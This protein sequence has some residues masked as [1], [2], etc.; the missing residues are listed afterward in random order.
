LLF[1]D[2]YGLNRIYYHECKEGLYFSSEAK[3]L[4]KVLPELRHFNYDSFGET[5]SFGCVLQNRT[6]FKGIYL[7]PG[8]SLWKC[9]PGQ[10]IQKGSYF[11][12]SIWENQELLGETEYYTKLRETWSR[13]LPRYLRGKERVAISLTGGKDT[14]MIMAWLRSAPNALPCYTFGGLYRDCEDVKLARQIAKI[15][16]QSHQVIR[17]DRTFFKEFPNLAE[18]TVYLTDG[19]M[20]VSGS[21]ELFVNRVARQI[22]PIRLTGNYG[23]EILYSSI[24]FKPVCWDSGILEKE[25]QRLTEH[26]ANTYYSELLDN[27]LSFVAFKQV[28]WHHYSRL[29]LELSQITPRS[30]YLDNELVSLA[31]RAPRELVKCIEIQLRL[32]MDGNQALGKV[33]TD[34]GVLYKP[35]P[36]FNKINRLSK[37]FTFKAEYAYDYGMP[38]LLVRIDHMFKHFHLE[39][40]FL[41]RHKFCHFRIWYRDELS[42]YLKEILLDRRSI[43]RGYLNGRRLENMVMDHIKGIRNYTSD[44]HRIL[45]AELIQRHFID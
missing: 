28:P 8:G 45:T 16:Q 5:F 21:A 23:Q 39:K 30:P 43:T 29:S 12:Q 9:S 36:L 41:G 25:F 4:L 38:R 44:I 34:R 6:L 15:C 33:I 31:F 2:R 19:I 35:I 10:N 18:K 11:R 24:A 14:R 27:R 1:N 32:V 40:V 42:G 17:I 13:I 37:E 26:A 7:L 3:S 20:D 22:A